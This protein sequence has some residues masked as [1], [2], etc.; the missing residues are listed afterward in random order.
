VQIIALTA[1]SL[2]AVVN[3]FEAWAVVRRKPIMAGVFM[4]SAGMLVVS[5]AA[6]AYSE[7]LARPLLVAGLVFASLAALMNS[8]IVIGKVIWWRQFLRAG[9]ATGIYVLATLGLGIS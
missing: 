2:Y 8:W 4:I 1:A 3:V 9:V 7:P 5:A 6:L